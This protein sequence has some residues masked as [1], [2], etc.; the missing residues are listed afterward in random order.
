MKSKLVQ[1]LFYLFDNDNWRML[2]SWCSF[3]VHRSDCHREIDSR[4][5]N[6]YSSFYTVFAYTRWK[7]RCIGASIPAGYSSCYLLPPESLSHCYLRA[8]LRKR[9]RPSELP[10]QH[11]SIGPM[12]VYWSEALATLAKFPTNVVNQSIEPPRALAT[13]T[14]AWVR[15]NLLGCCKQKQCRLMGYSIS[16]ISCNKAHTW[17]A[18]K[19]ENT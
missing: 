4:E 10:I 2:S 17:K 18:T 19:R 8:W 13:S 9:S 5:M 1:T 15:S 12:Y 6:Q 7:N 11:A 3:A 16:F 14:I